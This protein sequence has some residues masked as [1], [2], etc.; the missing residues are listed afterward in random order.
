MKK[1]VILPVF[2]LCAT[3][4][5]VPAFATHPYEVC[6]LALDL[7]VLTRSLGGGQN[8]IRVTYFFTGSDKE[9]KEESDS[10]APPVNGFQ[11]LF[12]KEVT[13]D[14]YSSRRL[15]SVK[16]ESLGA[17]WVLTLKPTRTEKATPPLYCYQRAS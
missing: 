16:V 17:S 2:V 10:I 11:K 9:A 5:S 7:P 4:L 13:V 1:V 15:E 6:K 12:E 8:S 14:L 3:L